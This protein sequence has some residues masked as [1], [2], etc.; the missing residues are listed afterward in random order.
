MAD[1]AALLMHA[2]NTFAVLVAD[3]NDGK[4]QAAAR[5]EIMCTT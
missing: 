4:R 5:E 3:A 1:T 2:A